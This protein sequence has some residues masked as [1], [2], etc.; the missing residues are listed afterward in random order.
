M[1]KRYAVLYNYMSSSRLCVKEAKKDSRFLHTFVRYVLIYVIFII[2]SISLYLIL[3]SLFVV[4]CNKDDSITLENPK[5]MCTS[6]VELSNTNFIFNGQ[7]QEIENLE[8]LP[9][10][11][12]STKLLMKIR[13]ILPVDSFLTIP[14]NVVPAED[15]ITFSGENSDPRYD[16]EV[17]G[18][19]K[20]SYSSIHR[21]THNHVRLECS[22]KV[23][24]GI[25]L[26]HPYVFRFDKGCIDVASGNGG[27]YV[28]EDG[29]T[30]DKMAVAKIVIADICKNISKQ[31]SAMQFLFHENGT[32]DISLQN[33]GETQMKLWMTVPYWFSKSAPGITIVFNDSQSLEVY[34]QW[35]GIPDMFAPF[36]VPDVYDKKYPL[37]LFYNDNETFYFFFNP[38]VAYRMYQMYIQAKGLQGTTAEEQKYFTLFSHILSRS[39]DMNSWQFWFISENQ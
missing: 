14:V 17:R 4:S 6:P 11:G 22:Y 12:D 9:V 25:K 19:Y 30:Y 27:S 5:D 18:V 23:I 3:L 34:N 7:K 36:L 8:F 1:A 37:Q 20:K 32:L 13:G 2:S 35:T 29:T 39:K 10:K 38:Y 28:D 33:A 21:T 15:S 31:T 24:S 26:E 16:F